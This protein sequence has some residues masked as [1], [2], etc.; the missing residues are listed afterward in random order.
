MTSR[1]GLAISDDGLHF[2][3]QP[4]PVF[5]PMEDSMKKYEWKG[6]VED[7][8]I[9]ESEEGV[10][11]LTYTAYDGKTARL[12]LATSTDL[13]HWTPLTNLHLARSPQLILD[14]AAPGVPARFYRAR[15]WP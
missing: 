8:R 10:Y 11:I 3:K 13:L 5:Y 6:G 9:A 15:E 12:C 14:T 7:P 4:E 1:I 2:S